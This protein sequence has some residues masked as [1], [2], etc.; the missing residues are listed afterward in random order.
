MPRRPNPTLSAFLSK[1]N[2]AKLGRMGEDEQKPSTTKSSER[3]S[4]RQQQQLLK[5]AMVKVAC[6]VNGMSELVD[7]DDED[8]G[9]ALKAADDVAP[10]W[11]SLTKYSRDP[12]LPKE[13]KQYLDS[14]PGPRSPDASHGVR[15]GMGLPAEEAHPPKH[16]SQSSQ[17]KNLLEKMQEAI[18]S[19][20]KGTPRIPTATGSLANSAIAPERSYA[21]VVSGE[22]QAVP[23]AANFE[24]VDLEWTTVEGKRR[25]TRLAG[26][27]LRHLVNVNPEEFVNFLSLEDV[28]EVNSMLD[29]PEFL[30]IEI[31]L[32]SGAGDHVLS[33]VDV[34]GFTI[35][36][37]PGSRAQQHFVAAGG[38]R[39]P[40]EGQVRLHLLGQANTGIQSLFQ[41]AEVTRPL[42]SVGKICDQGF[43][44]RF[45]AKTA[46]ILKDGKEILSFERK[47]GLYLGM[48]KL[49]NPKYRPKDEQDFAGPS[50]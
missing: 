6:D 26:K 42:W 17:P 21:N 4:V 27:E 47:N 39:L 30:V 12:P 44:V 13:F 48:I 29:E 32:D 11:A 5:A 25:K 22:K 16:L 49:K 8:V 19:A 40:N 46:T 20:G 24:G 14:L 23:T 7:S 33:R 28:A 45:S 9:P 35:E 10:D 43:D 38:K 18:D 36:E 2:V 31:C 41:V 50:R 34:P 3:Q 37:S 1:D 15:G